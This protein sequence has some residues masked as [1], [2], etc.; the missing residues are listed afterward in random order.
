MRGQKKHIFSFVMMNFHIIQE[1]FKELIGLFSHDMMKK[2][3]YLV[4]K[5]PNS[6]WECFLIQQIVTALL[7]EQKV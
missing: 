6:G 5:L 7:G 4:N 3:F 2:H 1:F